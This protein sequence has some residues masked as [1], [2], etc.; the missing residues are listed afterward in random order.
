MTR[1]NRTI[2]HHV[3]TGF[4]ASLTITIT[5]AYSDYHAKFGCSRIVIIDIC[6]VS[7]NFFASEA[8]LLGSGGTVDAVNFFL[9]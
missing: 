4:G 2:L 9:M 3:T 1:D 7:Q 8:Q 6:R 5:P